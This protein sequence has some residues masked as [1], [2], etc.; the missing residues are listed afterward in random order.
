MKKN[1][2]FK[3]E[4]VVLFIILFLAGIFLYKYRNNFKQLRIVNL[5][6]LLPILLF[7][8]MIFI[9]NGLINKYLFRIFKINL[10]FSEWFG[11][12][13][14]STMSNFLL[15]VR[16]GIISNAVYLK[17]VHNFSYSKFATSLSTLY[18][19]A[20]WI[21]SLFGLIALIIIKEV[22]AIFSWSIFL[23]FILI[24]ISLTVIM[25]TSPKFSLTRNTYLNRI[26]EGINFWGELKKSKCEIIKIL[27]LTILMIVLGCLIYYFEFS[28]LG[29]FVSPLK[30]T[31]LTIFSGFSLLL[32][33]TPAGLGI[34]E[35]FAL[36]AGSLLGL[37]V[38]E[39]L[40]VSIVDRLI[41]FSLSFI[42]GSYFSMILLKLKRR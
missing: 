10:N 11:L 7:T 2:F 15:P 41:N 21:N 30:L 38:A 12:S 17:K 31:V 27:L 26:I 16:G 9:T 8:S 40:A 5:P 4:I 34:K 25:L 22:Y 32:S 6:A 37:N 23:T 20:F 24:F 35:A 18:I 33:V 1:N 14:I 29:E 3:L 28:L 42:F 13:V 39:I 19:L 36:Y